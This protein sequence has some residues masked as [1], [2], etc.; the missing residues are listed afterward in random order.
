MRRV[1][2]TTTPNSSQPGSTTRLTAKKS[3]LATK[4]SSQHRAIVLC[5]A[6][7]SATSWRS[8]ST[9]FPM[10]T[11]PVLTRNCNRD[12][13]ASSQISPL[14]KS[15]KPTS[16]AIA[17]A[18]KTSQKSCKSLISSYGLTMYDYRMSKNPSKLMSVPS[19]PTMVTD[20][21]HTQQTPYKDVNIRGANGNSRNFAKQK[22]ESD[23]KLEEWSQIFSLQ[24]NRW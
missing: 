14:S 17:S 9:M 3:Y 16:A 23:E 6:L 5:L 11:C 2:L 10:H 4:V 8:L 24:H 12:R 18:P 21:M 7:A 19:Q 1:P 13:K 22:S 20:K 15:T